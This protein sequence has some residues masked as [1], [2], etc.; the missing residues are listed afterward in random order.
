MHVDILTHINNIHFTDQCRYL[1]FRAEQKFE[2]KRL[3]N[4]LIRSH[5]VMIADF[6]ETLCYMEHNCASINLMKRRSTEKNK[7]ELN[8]STHEAHENDLEENSNYVYRGTKVY[9]RITT[10]NSISNTFKER[11]V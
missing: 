5:E 7:C 1:E 2:G 3:V 6:C 11:Q 10:Q 4:H 8:N 9:V